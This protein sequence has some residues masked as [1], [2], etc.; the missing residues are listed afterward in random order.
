MYR[1]NYCRSTAR[2]VTLIDGY[3]KIMDMGTRFD[4]ISEH[5]HTF[6]PG[7]AIQAQYNRLMLNAIILGG[8]F[9]GI[10]TE[11]WHFELPGAEIDLLID[12]M[13]GCNFSPQAENIRLKNM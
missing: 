6:H 2:D 9:T 5:F 12:D 3:G 11:G 1:R 10:A 13:C 8:G 7:V 4:E